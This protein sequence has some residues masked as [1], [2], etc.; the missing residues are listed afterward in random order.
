MEKKLLYSAFIWAFI[1]VASGVYYRELTKFS[2]FEFDV[3]QQLST[4]HTHLIV[5]GFV[6][7][8]L[9]FA[10]AKVLQARPAKSATLFFWFWNIGIVLTGGMMLL[11]GTLVVLGKAADSAAFAGIAG[12]GHI[13]LTVGFV[14]AFLW[15]KDALKNQQLPVSDEAELQRV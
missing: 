13:S 4:V 9:I 11:K 2:G 7:Q 3:H 10:V 1:G 5:L 15:L 12:L 14:A 8:L 6:I